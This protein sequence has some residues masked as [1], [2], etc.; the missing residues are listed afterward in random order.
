MR[1]KMSFVGYARVS[2]IGQ[3]LDLQLEKLSSCE[4][5]F[6]EKVKMDHEM[7][8]MTYDVIKLNKSDNQLNEINNLRFQM[9][10]KI[11]ELEIENKNLKNEKQKHEIDFKVFMDKF[12]EI[13]KKNEFESRELIFLKVKQSEVVKNKV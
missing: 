12:N 4:K 8:K 13:Y 5:L 7:Q 11:K 2:S 1:H 9:D 10:M 3:S 6:Q